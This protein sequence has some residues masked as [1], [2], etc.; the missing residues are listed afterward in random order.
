MDFLALYVNGGPFGL[1]IDW[2]PVGHRPSLDQMLQ[3]CKYVP[4]NLAL[5]TIVYASHYF[6]FVCQRSGHVAS[7]IKVF[8][9]ILKLL[10][11]QHNLHNWITGTFL[12]HRLF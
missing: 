6:Q 12:K 5:V 9:E 7:S 11:L 2:A 3:V 8:G 1:L 4:G 10:I